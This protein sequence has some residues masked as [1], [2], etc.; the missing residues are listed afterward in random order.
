MVCSDSGLLFY[1]VTTS[2]ETD[3]HGYVWGEYL[4]RKKLHFKRKLGEHMITHLMEKNCLLSGENCLKQNCHCCHHLFVAKSSFV[5]KAFVGSWEKELRIPMPYPFK[6]YNANM[7][8]VDLFDRFVS[9]YCVR[10]SSKNWWW[11]SF[12][13]SINA[14]TVNS[15]R[16]F[17]KIHRNKFYC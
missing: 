10:I 3:A 17:H 15:W 13:W 2:R 14:T 9:T 5:K 4:Q 7:K 16:W 1:Y 12:A 11:P 6:E 8:G